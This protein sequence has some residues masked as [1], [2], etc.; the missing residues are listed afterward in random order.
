MYSVYWA[1]SSCSESLQA[2]EF[3]KSISERK[4][5]YGRA[6]QYIGANGVHR[7]NINK[8]FN[9]SYLFLLSFSEVDPISTTLAE[10]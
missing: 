4:S 5:G 7:R 2:S 9:R 8:T 1:N 3:Q 6:S 10:A